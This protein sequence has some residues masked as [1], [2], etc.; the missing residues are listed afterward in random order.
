MPKLTIPVPLRWGD[1]DAFGHINNAMIVR[2]LEQARVMWFHEVDADVIDVVVA[3]HEIEYVASMPYTHE[4]PRVEL[5]IAALGGS[6]ADIHYEVREP[7]GGGDTVYVRA[8]TTAVFLD[9]DGRPRRI[10]DAER[11]LWSR[12]LDEPLRFRRG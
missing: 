8:A 6:H 9:P 5:W 2:V 11:A 4:P 7:A 3:R 1:M 10:T 12:Y